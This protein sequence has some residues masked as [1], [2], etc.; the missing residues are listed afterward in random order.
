LPAR[1]SYSTIASMARS[2]FGKKDP[3]SSSSLPSWTQVFGKGLL[4]R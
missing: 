4:S 2:G 1:L 3:V